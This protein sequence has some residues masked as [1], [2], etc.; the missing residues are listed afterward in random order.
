MILMPSA[1]RAMAA[2]TAA[3]LGL[4]AHDGVLV[5]HDRS[6]ELAEA[7]ELSALAGQRTRRD[8]HARSEDV[9]ARDG[10]AEREISSVAGVPD[11]AH[12]GESGAEHLARVACPAQGS[13]GIGELGGLDDHAGRL[14]GIARV[15]EVQEV[16]VRV[17]EPGQEHRIAEIDRAAALGRRAFADRRDAPVVDDDAR[18]SDERARGDVDVRARTD[19]QCGRLVGRDRRGRPR[20]GRGQGANGRAA[21]GDEDEREDR[22][23]H[24]ANHTRVRVGV[25][26]CGA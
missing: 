23:A 19:H 12:G 11:V 3:R 26:G 25:D 17:D 20:A 4:A 7:L 14:A 16:R 5:L 13:I 10:V 21:G 9:S 15:R 6:R 1:P 22:G 8:E 24:A 2:R 18:R